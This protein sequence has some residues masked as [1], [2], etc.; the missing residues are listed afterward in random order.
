MKRLS[1][2]PTAVY[3]ATHPLPLTARKPQTEFT[4]ALSVKLLQ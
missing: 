2:M 4:P 1:F 3:A